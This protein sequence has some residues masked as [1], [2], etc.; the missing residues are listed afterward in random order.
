MT[1][2]VF[3]TK[4]S[5]H[6]K[7]DNSAWQKKGRKL[8]LVRSRESNLDQEMTAVRLHRRNFSS[9]GSIVGLMDKELEF[10]NTET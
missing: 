1:H 10:K 7:D 2:N 8:S 3:S 9:P 6:D 5:A 4:L